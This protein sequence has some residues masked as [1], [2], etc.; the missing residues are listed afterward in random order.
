M[1]MQVNKAVIAVPAK[2]TDAQRAAT[3]EAFKR[4]GLKVP[5]VCSN[6]SID[7]IH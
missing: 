2:F 3:G 4:A 1:Y 7:V 6:I 5:S